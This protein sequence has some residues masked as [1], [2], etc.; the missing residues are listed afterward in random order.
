[1]NECKVTLDICQLAQ[2]MKAQFLVEKMKV[3]VESC[4]ERYGAF[5]EFRLLALLLELEDV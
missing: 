3:A 4:L 5:P 1:M 2:L